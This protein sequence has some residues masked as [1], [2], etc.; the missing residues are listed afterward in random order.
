MLYRIFITAV[1]YN[2]YTLRDCAMIRTTSLLPLLCL[3]LMSSFIICGEF[4]SDHEEP[5]EVR[6]DRE[7][8]PVRS[9]HS[10]SDI[11]GS[12]HEDA[13]SSSPVQVALSP[14]RKLSL[15][16]SAIPLAHAVSTSTLTTTSSATSSSNLGTQVAPR[17]LSSEENKNSAT[18]FQQHT[19]NRPVR[20]FRRQTS[21]SSVSSSSS[22]TATQTRQSASSSSSSSRTA[23]AQP[24]RENRS[25]EMSKR[26]LGDHVAGE[27][28]L[29]ITQGSAPVARTELGFLN[30]IWSTAQ[31]YVQCQRSITEAA[32]ADNT[33]CEKYPT[34]PSRF[35]AMSQTFTEYILQAEQ[36]F[37]KDHL[38]RLGASFIFAQQNNVAVLQDQSEAA[39]KIVRR[40]QREYAALEKLLATHVA[41]ATST[42][43]YQSKNPNKKQHAPASDSD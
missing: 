27:V 30:R 9:V 28:T 29:I 7:L 10:N 36:K 43:V 25:P 37:N 39:L 41:Q 34:A 24:S 23:T 18:L 32:I 31:P 6:S 20:S 2:L 22:S 15:P 40:K 26:N 21:G 35:T 13:V 33:F 3:S 14:A 16:A 1:S 17:R 11:D 5:V 19:A 12:D 4:V 42:A 38:I 8:S